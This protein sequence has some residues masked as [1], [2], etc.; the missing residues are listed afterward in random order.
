MSKKH[1]RHILNSYWSPYTASAENQSKS[2]AARRKERQKQDY[3]DVKDLII[4]HLM[5]AMHREQ[6]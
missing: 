3:E 6:R 2:A 5:E 1:K 4:Q